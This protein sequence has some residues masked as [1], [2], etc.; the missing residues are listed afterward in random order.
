M[1]G[2]GVKKKVGALMLTQNEGERGEEETLER[3]GREGGRGGRG[4]EREGREGERGVARPSRILRS[5]YPYL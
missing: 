5:A 3:V 1:G 4:G 2:R